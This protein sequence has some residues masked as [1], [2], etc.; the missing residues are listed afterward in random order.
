MLIRIRIGADVYK[1]AVSKVGYGQ[2]Q[3][4]VRAHLTAVYGPAIFLVFAALTGSRQRHRS[5]VDI[6]MEDDSTW[7]T[8]CIVSAIRDG[9]EVDAIDPCF[10]TALQA[11]AVIGCVVKTTVLPEHGVDPLAYSLAHQ[12]AIHTAAIYNHE[13]VLALLL[14]SCHEVIDYEVTG[15]EE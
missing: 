4:T 9:A 14:K 13:D 11:S 3:F 1:P 10:G 12:S 8:A 7:V 6:V 2:V 15:A 5:L